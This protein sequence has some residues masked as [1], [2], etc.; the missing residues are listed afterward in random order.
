MYIKTSAISGEN[1]DKNILRNVSLNS[2]DV[3]LLTF[4][5]FSFCV[6]YSI[7]CFLVCLLLFNFVLFLIV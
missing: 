1:S 6:Y 5:L 7:F 2:I 4:H 3:M